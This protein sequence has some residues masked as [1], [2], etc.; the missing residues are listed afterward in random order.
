VFARRKIGQPPALFR[1]TSG[2]VGD[3]SRTSMGPMKEWHII[4]P[5]SVFARQERELK[6]L[7]RAVKEAKASSKKPV[8]GDHPISR[9]PIMFT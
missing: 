2:A 3:S 7:S 9:R 6:G 5:N 8:S 4:R 1:I